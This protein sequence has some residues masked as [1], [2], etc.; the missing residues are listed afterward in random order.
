[1]IRRSK[2]AEVEIF[3]LS[4]LD[5]IACGFGA[6]VMLLLISR[7]FDDSPTPEPTP[8]VPARQLFELMAEN[9][10]AGAR[11]AELAGERAALE[12]QLV[13]AQAR[14]E[15][16][17]AAA[18]QSAERSSTAEEVVDRMRVAQQTLT[19][20]M[21]RREPVKMP[22][23]SVGGIVVDSEYIIF[24]IDTSG[25]MQQIWSRVTAEVGNVLDIHPT[26]KG[27]QIMSDRGA[28]LFDTTRGQWITN[29]PGMRRGAQSLIEIW[30]VFSQSDPV[31]GLAAAIR[32]FYDPKKRISIFVFGDEFTGASIEA[33]VK[34]IDRLN[35]P[36]ASGARKVQI[37]AV[38][39]LNQISLGQYTGSRFA[40]LMREVT[41][42][43]GGTFV[44]LPNSDVAGVTAWPGPNL[45]RPN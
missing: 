12:Q 8:E 15:R 38:G 23:N 6:I 27:F 36:D 33:T 19:E 17:R 3:S 5:I 29:S 20:E 35:T 37:H 4:F 44:G 34:E 24:V 28:Y 30:N 40:N 2:R 21:Q 1:M 18:R 16:A 14:L 32:T 42:R 7:P 31:P 26:V 41:Q 43:N 39:F 11:N 10:A 9:A 25:S 13:E 45:V 22:S